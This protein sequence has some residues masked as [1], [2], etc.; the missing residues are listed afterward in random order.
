MNEKEKMLMLINAYGIDSIEGLLFSYLNT[1]RKDVST[2][3][4][5]KLITD[6]NNYLGTRINNLEA[7]KYVANERAANLKFYLEGKMWKDEESAKKNL[8]PQ[9]EN[10]Q[11]IIDACKSMG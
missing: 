7:I 8:Q 5:F 10:A 4:L 2:T 6:L 1:Y 3:R 9:I 11:A